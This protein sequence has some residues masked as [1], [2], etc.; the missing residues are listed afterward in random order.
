MSK[1]NW[2]SWFTFTASR[3]KSSTSCIKFRPQLTV[4]E[5]RIAPSPTL[6]P[7]ASHGQAAHLAHP[8]NGNHSGQVNGNHY[9][10]VGSIS[11]SVIDSQDGS[12]VVGATVTLTSSTG[13]ILTTTTDANGNFSFAN[14]QPDTYT[15]TETTA[16]GWVSTGSTAG[17]AGGD[18]SV[19][20]QVSGI[21]VG[22]G[23]NAT[24]YSLQESPHIF[25]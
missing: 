17:T 25:A 3:K 10:Q 13:V 4:L 18:V 9:G 20:G 16:Q 7:A 8:N 22:S 24:G 12:A 6:P 21:V 5:G 11:G 14:L 1:M 23:T 15:L 19:A 2:K